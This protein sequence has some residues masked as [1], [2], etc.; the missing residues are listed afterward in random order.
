MRRASGRPFYG[1]TMLGALSLAQ[2][3]AWG[4]LYYGFAVFMLP[5]E[6]ELG[7]SRA[8]LSGAFS[9]GLLTSALAAI[10]IGRYIDRRGARE[11]MLCGSCAAVALLLAWA[12]VETRAA[13]YAIWF[14]L[15]LTMAAVLYEPAFAIVVAWFE[16]R[17]ATALSVLTS[18]GGFA[19]TIFVPAIT[20]LVI[21]TNWRTTLLVLAGLLTVI[22]IPIYTW[23]VRSRPGDLG[24]Q[25][26]GASGRT[27]TGDARVRE[28][29]HADR[30][31]LPRGRVWALALAFGLT[32]LAS[33]AAFVH[34]Y[35]FLIATGRREQAAAL[36]IGLAGAAQVPGRLAFGAINRAI[37][38]AWLTPAVF[39]IQA[40][41]LACLAL[42]RH[43]SILVIAFAL[44]FGAGTGLCTLVRAKLVADRFALVEY[45]TV[46]G[47]IAASGLIARA[48]GPFIAASAAA[49]FGGY[50]MVWWLMMTATC[51]GA[52]LLRAQ[53]HA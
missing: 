35:P 48:A 7:W 50:E 39:L 29:P 19:S 36:V 24:L 12:H 52:L 45:A 31:D 38:A 30:V 23:V 4:V 10:P 43:A 8:E 51:A 49:M 22:L 11:L 26:D 32:T 40:M 28:W 9:I 37:P 5:M 47:K 14:G 20:H 53:H 15:G 16:R 33:S 6:R 18:V 41:G 13:F 46:S 34:A 17:R 1:W 3:T 2:V 21:K 44:L 25:P 27:H 42:A